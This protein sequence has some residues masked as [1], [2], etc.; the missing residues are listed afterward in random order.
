MSNIDKRVLGVAICIPLVTAILSNSF[1]SEA[2]LSWY[3]NLNHPWY[4]LPLA[5]SIVVALF[6]YIGYGVIIYRSFVKRFLSAVTL[7]TAV[8]VANEIWNVVF[9]GSRNLTLTFWVTLAF[10]VLVLAQA[11]HVK[12]KDKLSLRISLIYLAWVVAYDLPWLYQL[13]VMNPAN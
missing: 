12:T 3:N 2:A 6:V 7:A 13:S 9:F 1:I 4:K 5:G 8:I 11:L 10:A